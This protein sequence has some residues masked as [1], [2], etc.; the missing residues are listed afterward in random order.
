MKF[1]ISDSKFGHFGIVFREIAGVNKLLR[2]F[3]PDDRDTVLSH[4]HNEYL[5]A[6]ESNHGMDDLI[7]LIVDYLEGEKVSIPM[8]F[9]DESICSRFQLRVLNAER[10]IPYGKT[11]T[12]SWVARETDTSSARAVGSAL[13]RNPF[14]II[15]PCHRAIRADRTVGGFQGGGRMKRAFLQMEGVSFDGVARVVEEDI[16]R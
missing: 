5:A 6:Q 10:M 8:T 7:E 16:M 3:L 9:V 13:A 4:V 14:P 12:Y 15:V 11:A 1:S 2:L